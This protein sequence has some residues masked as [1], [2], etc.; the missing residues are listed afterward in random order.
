MNVLNSPNFLGPALCFERPLPSTV[1]R[2]VA[3]LPFC[4]LLPHDSYA[5]SRSC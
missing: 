1:I 4:Y 2:I 5:E 3:S